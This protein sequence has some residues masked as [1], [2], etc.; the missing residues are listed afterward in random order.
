M[1]L[2][3]TD[4]ESRYFSNPIKTAERYSDWGWWIVMAACVLTIIWKGENEK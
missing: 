4:E 1:K 2:K 3:W